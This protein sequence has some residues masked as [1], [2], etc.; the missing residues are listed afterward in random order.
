MSKIVIP[1]DVWNIIVNYRGVC[2]PERPPMPEFF[3]YRTGT[4][5]T[6]IKFN[7]IGRIRLNANKTGYAITLSGQ[8]HPIFISLDRNIDV[9]T[10]LEQILDVNTLYNKKLREYYTTLKKVSG[11]AKKIRIRYQSTFFLA[12]VSPLEPPE[13]LTMPES[14]RYTPMMPQACFTEKLPIPPHL[15]VSK[16]RSGPHLRVDIHSG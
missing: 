3:E 6:Y 11:L 2:L 9:F 4:E 16:R 10:M 15:P 13:K 12:Q 14:D 8:N 1:K 5:V 7:D